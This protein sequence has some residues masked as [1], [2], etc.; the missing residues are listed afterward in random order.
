MKSVEQHPRAAEDQRQRRAGLRPRRQLGLGRAAAPDARRAD[1]RGGADAPRHELHHDPQLGRQQQPRG[2]LRQSATSTAC[3]CGTTSPTPGRW[4]RRT[5]TRS[6]TWP[7]TPCCAT[8]STPAWW[9][10]AAP[11]RATRPPRSTT[12]CATPSSR[13]PPASST[14]TTR[15]A[16]SSPAAARTTG[17]SRER[18]YYPST[19]GSSSFGFH[20]EIGMPVVSTAESMRNLVGDEPEWP[21]GGAWYYHDWSSSGNQAPQ[22]YQAA[23]ET[24]LGTATGPRRLRP[25]GAVRQ[26]REH[27][28]HVRGVERQPV[29]GRQR[30]DAVDVPPRVAQH[31]LA[32]LRLRLR[33]QRHLLRGPQG[34]RDRCTSRPTRSTGGS[35]RSTTPRASCEGAT[36]T[37]RRL[38]PG[39]TPARRR[40]Q[41]HGVDV[42]SS[43]TA[44][45][46]HRRLDRTSLPDLHLLRLSLD[47]R[48]GREL[49]GEHLLALPRDPPTCRRSTRPG[50]C[51]VS[52]DRR[53]TDR[54]G[55][56]RDADRDGHATAGRRSPRWCGCRCWT[57]GRG[58]RVLPT[59]YSDNYLWLLPGESRTV[60][61][62]WP[63]EA[64]PS[65]RPATAGGGV[66]QPGCHREVTGRGPAFLLSRGRRSGNLGHE[67]FNDTQAAPGPPGLAADRGGARGGGRRRVGRLAG[68]TA[69][70]RLHPGRTGS[71]P[72]R[73]ER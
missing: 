28:R 7:A 49:S 52:V 14:R 38:R 39:R 26:L 73:R 67:A 55:T 10:G 8:A 45:R 27:P 35:S 22:N 21:I 53:V 71:R 33:R 30:A 44:A 2:V 56:R 43:A 34:V 64:L 29:G 32:D 6:T 47:G 70:R 24:R 36:V 65:G 18:Y 37:A 11:T 31:G 46:V 5:T 58:E 62:S 3:W 19:Y 16:A 54:S 42:A 68:V 51:R 12:A 20:T 23:I 41:R 63:A 15:P 17:S 9:C 59:L 69:G 50:R 57:T 13:R 61:L 66:Q 4:T 48:H 1:G 72:A 60:T 40:P 25:Q